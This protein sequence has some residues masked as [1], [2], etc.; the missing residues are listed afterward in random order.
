MRIQ[1]FYFLLIVCAFSCGSVK[2]IPGTYRSWAHSKRSLFFNVQLDFRKDST[3]EFRM[4]F[5]L[6]GDQATGRYRT[7]GNIIYL[8]YDPDKPYTSS[9]LSS[10]NENGRMFYLRYRNKKLFVCDSLGHMSR[11]NNRS[12]HF[13]RGNLF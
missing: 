12:Y 10:R 7:I 6:Q 9:G 8:K 13:I 1:I 11:V 2:D 4:M 5:D 3:F